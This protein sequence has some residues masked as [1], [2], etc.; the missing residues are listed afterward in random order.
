MNPQTQTYVWFYHIIHAHS[1][2]LTVYRASTKRL[3][4]Y[5]YPTWL[6]LSKKTTVSL[7]SATVSSLEMIAPAPSKAMERWGH[8]MSW[9]RLPG[10]TKHSGKW[11]TT[12]TSRLMWWSGLHIWCTDTLVNLLWSRPC[13]AAP[14]DS[15]RGH[16]LISGV[17]LSRLPRTCLLWSHTS[18]MWPIGLLYKWDYQPVRGRGAIRLDEDW[19][20]SPGTTVIMSC[21]PLCLI[22]WMLAS[23]KQMTRLIMKNRMKIMSLT[24][25]MEVSSDE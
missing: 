20:G 16:K 17:D 15:G 7:S 21:Q 12:G 24:V 9:K 22:S 11:V 13:Q 19:P 3:S 2:K 5:N 10:S 8:L 4:T 6:S 25:S 1:I 23:G 14:Q 18:S